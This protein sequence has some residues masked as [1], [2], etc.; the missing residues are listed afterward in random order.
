[1]TFLASDSAAAI[2]PQRLA[3]KMAGPQIGLGRV[4]QPALTRPKIILSRK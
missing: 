3:V 2:A 1:M 4:T